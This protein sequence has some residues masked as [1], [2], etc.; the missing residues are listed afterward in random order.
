MSLTL[1]QVNNLRDAA[2]HAYQ[3]E[4]T[5]S[6]PCELTL[7][8]WALES[9]WGAHSPGNNCFGIKANPLSHQGAQLLYTYEYFTPGE[10]QVWLDRVQGRTAVIVDATV[11]PDGRLRY[12]CQDWFAKFTTLADCFIKRANIFTLPMYLPFFAK[13][14][15]DRNLVSLVK[16]VGS[17]YATDPI[18]ADKILEIASIPE[19]QAAIKEVR[20]L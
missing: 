2:H 3:C 16:S 11:R 4:T 14:E 18:Y 19:V 7:A 6:V 10:A 1:S 12:K 13:Y 5:T 15:R 20:G 9:G 17:R 8:Q